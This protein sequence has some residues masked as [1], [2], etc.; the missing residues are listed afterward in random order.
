MSQSIG[1]T[2]KLLVGQRSFS[3]CYRYRM[4]GRSGL[5][6][7]EPRDTFMPKRILLVV[8]PYA[9]HLVRVSK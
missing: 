1:A 2:I 7:Y 8:V 5:S 4:R 9:R 3:M 6:T